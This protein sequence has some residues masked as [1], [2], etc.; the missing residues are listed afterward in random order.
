MRKKKNKY[1]TQ[2]IGGLSIMLAIIIFIVVIIV[3]F[4]HIKYGFD[5]NFLIP[6]FKIALV[7][8]TICFAIGLVGVDDSTDP[9]DGF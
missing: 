6:Y 5:R 8:D 2:F 1:T 9:L 7:I 3:E 4:A